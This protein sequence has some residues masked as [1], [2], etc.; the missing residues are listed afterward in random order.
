MT[1]KDEIP[2]VIDEA[3]TAWSALDALGKVGLGPVEA[4]V[5]PY[6]IRRSD[7]FHIP[8]THGSTEPHIATVIKSAIQLGIQLRAKVK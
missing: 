4:Q 6:L 5:G 3:P 1:I 8:W 7:G 2:R